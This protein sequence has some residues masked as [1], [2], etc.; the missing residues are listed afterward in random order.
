MQLV[1][2]R[3]KRRNSF[4]SAFTRQRFMIGRSPFSSHKL[5]WQAETLAFRLNSCKF[6]HVFTISCCLLLCILQKMW[7]KW[8]GAEGCFTQMDVKGDKKVCQSLAFFKQTI[9]C[10]Q[11]F[12]LNTN[13]VTNSIILHHTPSPRL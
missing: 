10:Q 1:N 6:L 3:G 12:V 8:V 5:I 11:C 9:H 7:A 4:L 2:E 13:I